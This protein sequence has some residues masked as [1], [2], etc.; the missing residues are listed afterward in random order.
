[1]VKDNI[2]VE[3]FATR[4]NSV[5]R[6]DA[7]VADSD[8]DI[9]RRFKAEGAIFLGKLHLTELA[10]VR[11]PPTRNPWN[12]AHTPGGSSSGTAAAVAAGMVPLAIG[13]QTGASVS[14]PAAFCGV[15]AFKPSS[16]SMS[17]WG[18]VPQAP[19]FDT[20]GIVGA[21]VADACAAFRAIRP[22]YLAPRAAA[23]H[24]AAK[25]DIVL[26]IDPL[27]DALSGDGQRAY[28]ATVDALRSAGHRLSSRV[29]PIPLGAIDAMLTLL[30]TYEV[31][32][33]HPHLLTFA[34]GAID[35]SLIDAIRQGL[36]IATEDYLHTRRQ[37]AQA[38][39]AVFADAATADAYLWPAA[40]GTAPEGLAWTGDW[41]FISPWTALG[42]PIVSMPAGLGDNGLPLGCLLCGR[43]GDDADFA[44]VAE[45]IAADG[46]GAMLPTLP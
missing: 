5:S 15:A 7:P 43:P 13:T 37:L 21:T 44:D 34:P 23:R 27:F 40:P 24:V 4:C 30:S 28:G 45:R 17:A 19:S 39:L 42:G 46:E 26:P 36:K 12:L 16:G 18:V 22:A 41:R 1:G 6:V 31:A 14:R 11:P 2:D 35:E 3:G 9:V 38:A 29:L 8:A 33:A 20:C 32:R 10:W 25:L